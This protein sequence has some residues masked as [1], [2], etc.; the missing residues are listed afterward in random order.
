MPHRVLEAVDTAGGRE[1]GPGG[2]SL[3]GT[4]D[5]I[6]RLRTQLLQTTTVRFPSRRKR[7]A[8]RFLDSNL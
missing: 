8:E 6:E 2:A 1:G 3:R 5:E 4:V 7:G